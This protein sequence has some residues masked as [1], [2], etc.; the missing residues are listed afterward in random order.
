MYRDGLDD[1]ASAL[2]VPLNMND[3][4]IGVFNVE[5]PHTR[6]FLSESGCCE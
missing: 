6:Y 3:K 4:T 1:A 5:S 2:T